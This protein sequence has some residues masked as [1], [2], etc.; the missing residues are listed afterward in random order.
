MRN[1]L[2]L[3]KIGLNLFKLVKLDIKKLWNF[4]A[5]CY[6]TYESLIYKEMPMI[7]FEIY[8]QK[9]SDKTSQALPPRIS[10]FISFLS[11]KLGKM[12]R[13]FIEWKWIIEILCI[14]GRGSNFYPIVTNFGSQIGLVKSKRNFFRQKK[15]NTS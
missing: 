7:I 4:D 11:V 3:A 15:I 8:Y 1:V 13:L 2:N 9:L 5:K 12:F 14:Y 10:S 6:D